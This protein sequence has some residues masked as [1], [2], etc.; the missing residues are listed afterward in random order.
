MLSIGLSC[1]PRRG[2][3]GAD[4]GEDLPEDAARYSHLSQLEG[5]FAGMAHDPRADF[6]QAA[7]EACERPVCDL[8]GKVGTLEKMTKVVG[9]CMKLQPDL[10]VT[11]P[12]A[13]QP[14][15]VDCIAYPIRNTFRLVL[16]PEYYKY[17]NFLIARS[18]FEGV[19]W[20]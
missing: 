5:D 8:F 13:G 15:P 1:R 9:Q 12:F 4:S 2:L 6:D 10:V 3:E 14:C 16:D 20:G 7:L 18:V 17:I 19:C 11:E